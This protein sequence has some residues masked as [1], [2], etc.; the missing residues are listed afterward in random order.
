MKIGDVEGQVEEISIN[1]M[2][3]YTPSFNLPLI[4]NVQVMNSRV[5]NCTHEGFIKYTFS[6]A[7]SHLVSNEDI[8]NRCIEPSMEEFHRKHGDL[9]LRRTEF[10][11]ETSGNFGRSFKIRI[12]VP[13]GEAKT[14]FMLQPELAGMILNRWDTERKKGS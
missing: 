4:P 5:L 7:F 1:Y 9:Q 8:I 14:L 13:K 6:L 10:F 3:L 11:F 12:F 2:K